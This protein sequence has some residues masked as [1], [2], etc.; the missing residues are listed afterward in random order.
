MDNPI[1]IL[2]VEDEALIA[3]WLDMELKQAGYEVCSLTATGEAAVEI[4]EKKNLIDIILMDI[5]LAG[6]INGIE[7]AR[8]IHTASD[9]PIIFMTGYPQKDLIEQVD[10]LK[11]VNYLTKPLKMGDLK[12]A[13][14][15]VIERL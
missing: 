9:I 4:V 8:R 5:H 7:A 15:S 11:T 6:R 10:K 3:L 1:R 13:I 12:N 14:T 2:V